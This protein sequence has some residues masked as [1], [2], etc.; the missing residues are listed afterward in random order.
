MNVQITAKNFDLTQ[1]IKDAIYKNLDKIERFLSPSHAI[2]ITSEITRYG[3]NISVS[4]AQ[5]KSFIKAEHTSHDLYMA[6]DRVFDT[7]ANKLKKIA[8]KANKH[9]ASI[10]YPELLDSGEAEVMEKTIVKRKKYEMKPMSEEEAILQMETLGHKSF[11]FYHAE[12]NTMC[13]L[14]KRHDGNYGLIESA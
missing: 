5:N 3:H 9:N 8:S 14:Y 13:L 1:G 2:H 10:R 11:M 12:K 4:L 7:L 6:I